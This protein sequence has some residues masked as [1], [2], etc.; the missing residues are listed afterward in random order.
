[1]MRKQSER[2][3]KSWLTVRCQVYSLRD[4]RAEERRD[5]RLAAKWQPWSTVVWQVYQYVPPPPRTQL[6]K[7]ETGWGVHWSP[8]PLTNHI[9]NIINKQN[10]ISW[11]IQP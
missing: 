3:D 11:L 2:I 6:S 4:E 1:V 5:F 9:M 8:L 7:V 10:P